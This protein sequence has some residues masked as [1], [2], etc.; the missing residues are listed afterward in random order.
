M[1][2][3]LYSVGNHQQIEETTYWMGDNVFKWYDWQGVNNI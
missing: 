3:L 2:R 1:Y